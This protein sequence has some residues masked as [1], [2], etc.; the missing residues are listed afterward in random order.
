L[1]NLEKKCESN[2]AIIS[3]KNISVTV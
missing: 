1:D 2:D 3:V